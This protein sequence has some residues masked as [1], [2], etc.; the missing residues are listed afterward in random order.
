MEKND[1]SL[2]TSGVCREL[3]VTLKPEK[4][5]VVSNVDDRDDAIP[6]N[7]DRSLPDDAAKNA[8]RQI[9]SRI[10]FRDFKEIARQLSGVGSPISGSD[11]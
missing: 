10:L 1:V 5:V 2:E 4:N 3:E 11:T 8:D 6:S 7:N 9:S